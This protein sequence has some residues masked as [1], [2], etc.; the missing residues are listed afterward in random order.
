MTMK[1]FIVYFNGHSPELIEVSNDVS[2]EMALEI[3]ARAVKKPTVGIELIPE[4]IIEFRGKLQAWK[5]ELM[6]FHIGG[7]TK[8]KQYLI[9][10]GTRL[11]AKYPHI[12]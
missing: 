2:K 1:T 12:L 6:F 4:E 9:E 3:A 11:K 8:K 10:E 7:P 5:D